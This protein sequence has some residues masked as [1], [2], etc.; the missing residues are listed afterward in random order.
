MFRIFR[1]ICFFIFSNF[2]FG[3]ENLNIK[4]W[5]S[6]DCKQTSFS[7]GDAIPYAQTPREWKN[8]CNN[9]KPCYMKT[10]K[11]SFLYNY[12]SI[13]DARSIAPE[14]YKIAT[15][16]EYEEL[17]N[18]IGESFELSKKITAAQHLL[19]YD[20]HTEEWDEVA[21]ELGDVE[22][23][24]LNTFSFNTEKTGYIDAQGIWGGIGGDSELDQKYLDIMDINSDLECSYWWSINTDG[25]LGVMSI[26]YCSQD[27]IGYNDEL[28]GYSFVGKENEYPLEMMGFSLRLI[29]SNE[30]SE[31]KLE[32]SFEQVKEDFEKLFFGDTWVITSLYPVSNFRPDGKWLH[33]E[34][35][36]DNE[37]FIIQGEDQ[38]IMSTEIVE[39]IYSEKNI[40]LNI[41]SNLSITVAYPK[42][43]ET[44]EYGDKEWETAGIIIFENG[45][46]KYT[47]IIEK[48]PDGRIPLTANWPGKKN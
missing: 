36:E 13:V 9:R 41:N 21:G 45:A 17:L 25:S 47:G 10:Q 3:Q 7:N 46:E 40:R 28:L 35:G 27:W 48:G 38:N 39:I 20:Y 29:K 8:Y 43:I 15:R 18:S 26:G 11:G 16:G 33:L 31:I 6:N 37:T 42:G 5:Q 12:Y 4:N 32:T 23:K 2:V 14:G 34:M 19:N 44:N 24:G 30:S 22:H 1:I